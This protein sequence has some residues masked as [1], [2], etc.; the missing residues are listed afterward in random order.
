MI[1]FFAAMLASRKLW[2]NTA[3]APKGGHQPG[4][5]VHRHGYRM[6]DFRSPGWRAMFT[7]ADHTPD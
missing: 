4:F 3:S 7:S 6:I 2:I 5:L 1:E